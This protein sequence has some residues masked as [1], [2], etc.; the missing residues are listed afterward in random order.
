M[1]AKNGNQ[2]LQSIE[3]NDVT[4]DFTATTFTKTSRLAFTDKRLDGTDFTWFRSWNHERITNEAEALKIVSHNTTIPVPQLLDYGSYQDGRRYLVTEFI[5]GIRLDQIRHRGC[6][7]PDEQK[8]TDDTTCEPCSAQA[9]SN[10]LEFIQRTV[11]PQLANLKSRSR[12]ILGF[13]MPPSWMSPDMEPPWKGKVK[14]ETLPLKEPGYTFQHG[15]LAAHNIIID[16]KT[17]EVKALIDW[18]HA[19]YFPP[20][21]E[22][23][24][25][26]LDKDAYIKR[27]NHLAPAIA[28]FLAIE[29]LECYEKWKDKEELKA[30]IER[31][32]LPDPDQARQ[33]LKVVKEK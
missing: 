16:R 7:M 4:Y 20:G 13:V 3:T 26:T 21:M 14:W 17:L 30:L 33:V 24:P 1:E 25:G 9:Y 2:I 29:Y 31:G 18:E 8:H 10:A 11:L 32:E 12:E 22:R 28:Q 6:L 5:E 23:W 27:G 15:D 19:G